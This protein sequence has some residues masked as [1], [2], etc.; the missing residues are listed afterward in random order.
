MKIEPSSWQDIKAEDWSPYV[1]PFW[2]A[3][4]R[5][6]LTFKGFFSL[7]RTGKLSTFF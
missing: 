7:L 1:A 6:A 2:P 3:V 4:I 5:S